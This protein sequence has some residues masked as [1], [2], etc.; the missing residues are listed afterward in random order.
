M[1]AQLLSV[2]VPFTE[3]GLQMGSSVGGPGV[4]LAT[5][6]DV[7]IDSVGVMDIQS[8]GAFVGQTSAAMSMLSASVQKI[9]SQGKVEIFAGGGKAPSACGPSGPVTPPDAGPPG[10][11]MEKV[12]GVACAALSTTSAD[13]GMQD[14]YS[15]TIAIAAPGLVAQVP[16]VAVASI[17]AFGN[18]TALATAVGYPGD[19]APDIEE[20]A[21]GN[22][23]M[24]AGKKISGVAP[25]II[26]SK[27][28]G[29]FEVKALAVTDFTT[30][31]FTN[32]ALAKFEVKALDAFKTTS[33]I[34]E[35]EADVAVEI[36]TKD[37]KG[38][39]TQITMDGHTKV[40]E[41]MEV[42]GKTTCN[43]DL[44]VEHDAKLTGMLNV[45]GKTEVKGT[46]TVKKNTKVTSTATI[47]GDVKTDT[48]EFKSSVTFGV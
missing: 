9:H 48:A 7:L 16:A 1:T 5:A 18:L 4:S 10:A 14:A 39:S 32:F 37:F 35:I 34:F 15:P 45:T 3:T 8:M 24:V 29:K 47:D 21:S 25:A 38:K 43:A 41:S 28:P 27:T 19:G 44:Q 36:K 22:I 17:A 33:A 6:G 42:M 13:F 46:L 12:T 20:R 31:L 2:Q 30:V 26:S 23:K 40:T 11:T